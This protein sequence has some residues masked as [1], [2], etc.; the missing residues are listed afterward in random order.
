MKTFPKKLCILSY[1]QRLCMP[2]TVPNHPLGIFTSFSVTSRKKE[3]ETQEKGKKQKSG[4]PGFRC[5]SQTLADTQ[6]L[7]DFWEKYIITDLKGQHKYEHA[8]V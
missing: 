7:V 6:Q 8:L 5:Y 1:K 4:L 3:E 2:F